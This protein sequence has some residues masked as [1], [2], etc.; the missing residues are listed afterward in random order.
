[1]TAKE[2]FMSPQNKVYRSTLHHKTPRLLW[3][4]T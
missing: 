4:V 3:A 1:M 2:L